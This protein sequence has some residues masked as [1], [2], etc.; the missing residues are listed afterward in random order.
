MKKLR[1]FSSFEEQK[2]AEIA[3][4]LGL[5]PLERIAQTLV[6]IKKIYNCSENDAPKKLKLN[7]I[8]LLDY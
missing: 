8:K 3:Y 6:F 5:V 2:Q 1:F 4:T 7:Y